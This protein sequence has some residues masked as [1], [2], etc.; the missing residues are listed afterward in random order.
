[1]KVA[2][3]ICFGGFSLSPLAVKRM[4]ELQGRECYFFHNARKADGHIDLDRLENISLEQATDEGLFWNAYDIPNP[5]DFIRQQKDW[6]EMTADEKS[7]ANELYSKHNLSSRNY[8]RHDPLLIQ[9]IEELGTKA[10]G[11]CADLRIVEIP[12]GTDYE[13]SEYDGNEHIAEKHRTWR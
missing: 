2:I 8:D 4:A 5:D 3:N 1:M 6:S 10:N 12:D 11:H 9:V 13:I 7:A